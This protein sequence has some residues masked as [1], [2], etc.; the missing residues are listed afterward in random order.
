MKP[1]THETHFYKTKQEI[2]NSHGPDLPARIL[3]ASR[4][5]FI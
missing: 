2:N 1:M 4:K 5:T 3:L